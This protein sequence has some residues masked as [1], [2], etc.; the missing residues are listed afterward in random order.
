LSSS[1]LPLTAGRGN[2]AHL[3]F[4]YS[5]RVSSRDFIPGRAV[6]LPIAVKLVSSRDFIPGRAA[7]L[8][9]AV[10]LVSSRD[11]IPGRACLSPYSG[12]TCQLLRDN[13]REGCLPPL[14]G[15]I[16]V[17]IIRPGFD[18]VRNI[19]RLTFATK[20]PFSS[21]GAAIPANAVDLYKP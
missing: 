12:E 8:P 2:L 16:G 9:I 11:F 6:S 13:A 10:K 18:R 1:W 19:S 15:E 3:N 7:S 21:P 17:L 4:S 14:S 5:G 20:N